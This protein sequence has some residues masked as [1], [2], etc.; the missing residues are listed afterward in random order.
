MARMVHGSLKIVLSNYETVRIFYDF[1]GDKSSVFSRTTFLRK[2]RKL[3][4][5]LSYVHLQ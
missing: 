4:N 3:G 5:D 2:S 1:M